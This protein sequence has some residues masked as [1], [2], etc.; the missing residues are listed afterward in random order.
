MLKS[1]DIKGTVDAKELKVSGVKVRVR[2]LWPGYS[3]EWKMFKANSGKGWKAQSK[4]A[5]QYYRA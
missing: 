5:S 1:S 2:K 4:R 3:A